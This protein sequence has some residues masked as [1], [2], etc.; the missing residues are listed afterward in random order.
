[1]LLSPT[2]EADMQKHSKE[3]AALAAE[4]DRLW[5]AWG[6]A[7]TERDQDRLRAAFFAVTAQ[8]RAIDEAGE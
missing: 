3:W 5:R 8:A 7:T 4:S 2:M 1:M 6:K